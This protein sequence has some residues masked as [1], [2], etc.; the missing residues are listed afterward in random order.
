VRILADL[1]ATWV[2]RFTQQLKLC[3]LKAAWDCAVVLK[4][5]EAWQQLAV[6]A[7][8]QLDVELAVAAYRQLGNASMVLSLEKLQQHEDRNLLSAHILVLLERDY[9]AAQVPP[10]P[11][12]VFRSPIGSV[13]H[14]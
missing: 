3:Q 4:T 8:E 6:A 2:C 5:P 10:L 14:T 11:A 9:N 1:L 12:H 13:A 7:L